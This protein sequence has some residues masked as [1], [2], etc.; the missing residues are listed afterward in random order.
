[1]AFKKGESGNPAGRPKTTEAFRKL[2]K[3]STEEALQ[4]VKEIMNNRFAEHKDRLTAA[5]IILDK[6]LGTNY[7]LFDDDA[8][9]EDSVIKVKVIK[10]KQ[11]DEEE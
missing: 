9:F 8:D 7:K 10:A 2:L 4:T 11:R 5:K 6:G 1:M 3:E